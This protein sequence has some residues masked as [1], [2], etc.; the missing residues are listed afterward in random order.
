MMAHS[1]ILSPSSSISSKKKKS[2]HFT[3]L[4][5]LTFSDS[6]TFPINNAVKRIDY[7]MARNSSSLHVIASLENGVRLIGGIPHELK[8]YNSDEKK[9]DATASERIKERMK[10]GVFE[11][12]AVTWPSDHFGLVVD[13]DVFTCS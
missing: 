12:A 9:M 1:M 2:I 13:V 6:D 10:L 3:D 4:A 8:Q 11:N 5:T 7:I